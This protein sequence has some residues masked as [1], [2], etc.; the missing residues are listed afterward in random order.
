MIACVERPMSICIILRVARVGLKVKAT[1][2]CNHEVDA[3][4]GVVQVPDILFKEAMAW[5]S[6]TRH[7]PIMACPNCRQQAGYAR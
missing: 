2:Y 7:Q 3:A 5:T 4:Q 1:T 6:P